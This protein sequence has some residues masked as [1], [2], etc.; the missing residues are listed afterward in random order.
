MGENFILFIFLSL[1]TLLLASIF[2]FFHTA[3]PKIKERKG[4]SLICGNLLVL[5]FLISVFVLF[6]EC[7]FR[8]YYDSTDSFGLCK[9]TTRWFERHFVRNRTGFRDSSNYMPTVEPGKRRISFVG[10]SFTVGHGIADVEKRFANQFRSLRPDYEIHVL[11]ECG[12]DTDMELKLLEFL[13]QSGY[14]VDVVV[15]VYCLNDISDITP[16]WQTILNRIYNGPKPGFL[17]T[18]SYL[19]NTINARL[20]MVSEPEI[21]DYYSFVQKAYTGNVWEQQQKRLKDCHEAVARSGGELVVVTFPFLH[22]LGHDY[23]YYDIH[24]RL[25]DFWGGLDVPH[26]DL[27]EVYNVQR[28]D[29]LVVSSH[30][31]HPNEKAHGIAALSIT[32]FL[33]EQLNQSELFVK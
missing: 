28:S 25:D 20:Q 2:W 32:R 18:H 22:A 5:S 6:G 10:D 29:Q 7:Y 15:L 27:L 12:W 8:F 30:D 33:D 14:Q 21:I 11:A 24:E 4:F 26:L 9:T 19:F 1:P 13:P 31:A 23:G 17:A 3:L 16:A